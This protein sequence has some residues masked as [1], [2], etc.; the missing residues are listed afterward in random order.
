[1]PCGPRGDPG[2]QGGAAVLFPVASGLVPDVRDARRL[3]QDQA[4]QFHPDV[5]P[6]H[7][8]NPVILSKIFLPL[9]PNPSARVILHSYR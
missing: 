1:M 5:Q 6:S 8:V 2:Q 3:A 9:F 7:P 4:L